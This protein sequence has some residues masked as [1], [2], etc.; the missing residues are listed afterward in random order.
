MFPMF[1]SSH[2]NQSKLFLFYKE[3]V[4]GVPRLFIPS[5]VDGY[6]SCLQFWT[7][8][9]KKEYTAHLQASEQ[10]HFYSSWNRNCHVGIPH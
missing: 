1:M 3:Y 7:S 8:V 9:N 2:K 4:T 6:L 5:P 10:V